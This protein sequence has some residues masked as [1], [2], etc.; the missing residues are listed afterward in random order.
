MKRKKFDESTRLSRSIAMALLFALGM[1]AHAQSED[2]DTS[3][4]T[5]RGFGTLAATTHDA[6]GIEFRRS[7]NQPDGVREGDIDLAVDSQ[8]GLQF[9]LK[10]APHFDAVV[11]GVTRMH[12]DGNWAPRV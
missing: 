5:V 12:P 4:L 8:A 9:N 2:L 11:Q 1:S 6:E 3:W 7:M 10:L